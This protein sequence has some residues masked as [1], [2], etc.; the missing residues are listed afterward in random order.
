MFKS[1][2]GKWYASSFIEFLKT[3][4]Q[5][6][7]RI[8]H[9]IFAPQFSIDGYLVAFMAVP[10]AMDHVTLS[11]HRREHEFN[12]RQRGYA[13]FDRKNKDS[14]NDVSSHSHSSQA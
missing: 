3:K 9:S 11:R 14:G 8:T 5:I 1:L 7:Q 2:S 12:F 10:R 13:P 6:Q 4:S